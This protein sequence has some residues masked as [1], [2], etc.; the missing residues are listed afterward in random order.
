MNPLDYCIDKA[1]QHDSG[2]RIRVYA[3]ATNKQGRIIAEAGNDYC[4]TH[5]TQ[6]MYASSVGLGEKQYLHSE[7]ACLI[8]CLRKRVVPV[9]MYVARVH[10]DGRVAAACPCVICAKAIEMSGVRDVITT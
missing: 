4:K 9:K 1:R 6:A 8:I 10:R 2:G 7:V 5:P 3:V